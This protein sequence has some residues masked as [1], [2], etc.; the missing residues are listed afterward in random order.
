[1]F[2]LSLKDAKRVGVVLPILELLS[3]LFLLKPKK[4]LSGIA[5][6]PTSPVSLVTTP[7]LTAVNSPRSNYQR[8]SGESEGCGSRKSCSDA[9]FE[10]RRPRRRNVQPVH[11]EVGNMIR[12]WSLNVGNEN[13]AI[14]RGSACRLSAR[15]QTGYRVSACEKYNNRWENRLAHASCAHLVVQ[16]FVRYS[17]E[18]LFLDSSDCRTR[19]R[20]AL[21]THTRHEKLYCTGVVNYSVFQRMK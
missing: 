13:S 15:G 20:L 3:R 19:L 1:M 14:T 9:V 5:R 6:H 18:K 21:Q 7:V 2:F 8:I 11:T 4:I 16:I 17:S 12:Q 10:A